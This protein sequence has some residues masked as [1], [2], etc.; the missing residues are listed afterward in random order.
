[1][2]APVRD[3]AADVRSVAGG[4]DH[5]EGVTLARRVVAAFRLRTNTLA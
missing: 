2:T 4:I 1:M 3:A 5:P